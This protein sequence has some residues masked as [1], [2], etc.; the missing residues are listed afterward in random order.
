MTEHK[1]SRAEY[2]RAYRQANKERLNAAH[3][4]KR[5][6][7]TRENEARYREKKRLLREIEQMPHG[8][9]GGSEC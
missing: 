7:A 2:M 6:D 9:I 5:S 8:P 3:K 4:A 1:P